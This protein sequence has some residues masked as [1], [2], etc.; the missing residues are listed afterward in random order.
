MSA[1]GAGSQAEA[2]RD[3]RHIP[4]RPP[5][6]VCMCGSVA[7]QRDFQLTHNAPHSTPSFTGM[8]GAPRVELPARTRRG[9]RPL[10]S[11]ARPRAAQV[12]GDLQIGQ[13]QP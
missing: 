1:N 9:R 11:G 7:P 3:A 8:G 4:L 10:S 5:V 13:P 12:S 6:P 2:G